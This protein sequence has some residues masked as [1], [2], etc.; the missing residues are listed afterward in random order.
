MQTTLGKVFVSWRKVS[1]ADSPN[2]YV[3]TVLMRAYFSYVRLHRSY[4]R[5]MGEP[6]EQPAAA[7][8]PAPRIAPAQALATLSPQD[9]AVVVLR[10]WEDRSVA[11][12]A[13]ELG[14]SS[15][16]GWHNSSMRTRQ[17]CRSRQRLWYGEDSPAAAGRRT[18]RRRRFLGGLAVCAAPWRAGSCS[19]G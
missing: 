15:P 1:R 14:M 17:S 4:E 3:R 5:P 11:Q 19:P 6:P 13:A 2:A 7:R 10:N 12:T 16:P 18:K 9:R 8:D